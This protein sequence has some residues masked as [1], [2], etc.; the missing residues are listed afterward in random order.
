[1]SILG[2]LFS[3]EERTLIRRAAKSTWERENSPGPEVQTANMKFPI[4]DPHLNNNNPANRREMGDLRSIIAKGIRESVP[5]S[6][7][8]AKDF[9]IQQGNDEE[10]ADFLHMLK[11]QMRKYSG[12][13]L[14][15]LLGKGI[16]NFT[17]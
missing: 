4:E 5:Q 3:E 16:L 6:Q 2:T 15:D 9:D 7:N 10:P 13:Y 1:M 12:L 11:D 8:L 14:D 17:L